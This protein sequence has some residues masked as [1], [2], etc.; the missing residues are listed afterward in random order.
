VQ[1]GPS[2]EAGGTGS[3][4]GSR[5]RWL[6][7]LG[8]VAILAAGGAVAAWTLDLG[9]AVDAI[10]D[11]DPRLLA[12][13][14]AVY[15]CSWPLRG[16]R[17]ADLLAP[18][19]RRL[20]TAFLTGAIFVSQTAN[21]AIPARGGDA[22]RAVLLKRRRGV[23]YATGAASL[24]VERVVDLAAVVALGA[25]A[26]AA[27]L[28][29]GE[30]VPLA[31]AVGALDLPSP[32]L[33]AGGLAIGGACALAA[34]IVQYR[35]PRRWPPRAWRDVIPDRL[36]D[37]LV[38]AGS[39]LRVLAG[40]RRA[41]GGVAVGSVAIW[42]LDALTAV[43]VL[44]AVAGDPLSLLAAGT[45][46]VCAGN[47]AKVLPL[48]QGGIGLYEGAFAATVVAVSPVGAATALAAAV[49]DHALKNGVTLAGGGL[50]AL[51]IHRERPEPS[52]L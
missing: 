36:A 19:E 26:L 11:A 34:A 16:R 47:L 12:A 50:A 29:S 30:A 10:R 48:T 40:D 39:N 25:I 6:P 2:P 22:V 51:A 1:R 18:M 43:L 5:R 13:A 37:G 20:G 17:Y 8:T 28:G 7:V 14:V 49:L 42:A 15:T 41:L 4:S 38:L 32:A 27:L 9:T 45:L 52:G 46:A 44:A 24:A 31:D 3:A 33:V 21:L 35:S 23:A